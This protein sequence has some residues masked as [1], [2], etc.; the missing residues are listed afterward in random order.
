M[1]VCVDSV[2]SALNAERGGEYLIFSVCPNCECQRTNESRKLQPSI[3]LAVSERIF[4]R[5]E[6]SQLLTQSL[7]LTGSCIFIIYPGGYSPTCILAKK[8]MCGPKA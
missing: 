4:W 5:N 8:G 7:N 3:P 6:D 1:E 2:Q